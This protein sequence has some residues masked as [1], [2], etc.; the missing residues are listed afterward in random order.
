MPRQSQAPVLLLTRPLLQSRRFSAELAA[1]FPALR[2]EIS[3]L[4]QPEFR[5]PA[6]P[7]RPF[8]A[9]I[10]ASETA[11]AA[12]TALPDRPRLPQLAYCVGMRTAA[13]ARAAGF[14]TR[15]ADGDAEALFTLIRQEAPPCPLLFLRG[16]DS[17]GDLAERLTLAGTETLSCVVYQ[18][19]PQPLTGAAIALLQG[20]APV[21]VPLFSPRSARLFVA[22]GVGI[23]LVAPL[24]IAALSQAVA[25]ALPPLGVQRLVVAAR[26]DA[27]AMRA[28][29]AALIGPAGLP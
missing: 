28:A 14:Q 3:P 18:Q 19:V 17:T 4:L 26:A 29:V 12:T 8:G 23:G 21:I 2:I 15:S 16:E 13:A 7:D 25:A 6:L 20:R 10:F 9:V 1:E 5:R 24:H 27:G 11:V 22:A